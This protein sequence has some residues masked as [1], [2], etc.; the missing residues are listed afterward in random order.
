MHRPISVK[1]NYIRTLPSAGRSPDP[2]ELGLEST[3]ELSKA[4][5]QKTRKKRMQ[6]LSDLLARTGEEVV[7]AD[8][9]K[10]IR[11]RQ[12]PEFQSTQ[13]RTNRALPTNDSVKLIR[14]IIVCR[15]LSALRPRHSLAE[16]RLHR[17]QRV[18]DRC[19]RSWSRVLRHA[20]ARGPCIAACG[21]YNRSWYCSN[22]VLSTLNETIVN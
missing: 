2:L 16:P 17:R 1:L 7:D 8:E 9:G 3:E 11:D 5:K 13:M 19:Q 10:N 21:G 15:V 18:H 6:S 20:V 14:K 4:R 22:L 12:C